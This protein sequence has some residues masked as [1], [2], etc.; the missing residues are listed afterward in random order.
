MYDA[1]VAAWD[2]KYAYQ[3]QRP[4]QM[5]ATIQPIVADEHT[6]AYP[7]THAAVAGAAQ[8]AL[9]YLF[10]DDAAAFESIAEEAARSRLFA[11]A[12]L[13][14]D[15]SSGLE[16]GRAAGALAVTRAKQDGSDQ[17]FSGSF[18]PTPGK[19]SSPNPVAPLAGNWKPWV[20]TSTSLFRLTAP[21]AADSAAEADQIAMVK[22]V[23]RTPDI[24]RVAWFWQ[25]SFQFPWID[26]LS[27]KIFEY[28]WDSDP[29]LAARAYALATVGQH[30]A[31]LACWDTKYTYLAPRPSQVDPTVV[32]LFA[33]PAHP[34][35]PSGHA[36]GSSSAAAVL[37]T[38]FPA[39]AQFFRDKATEAGTSTFY[40]GIHFMLDVQA[41]LSLGQKVGKIVAAWPQG[42]M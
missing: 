15:T 34:S 37:G 12:Q 8:A 31:T 17:P 1:T 40:D 25:A 27:Q 41:G 21:P 30:D 11:G 13:P 29:P 33:N 32:T 5:D 24:L 10:P 38:L 19:W 6:P 36:C 28:H 4:S 35:Y 42:G 14:S 23:A 18:P 7:S 26:M 3:R 20:L 22:N 2:S 9:S 39:D 16:L